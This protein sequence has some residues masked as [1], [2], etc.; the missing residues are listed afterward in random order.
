MKKILCAA[1]LTL[2]LA[3]TLCAPSHALDHDTLKV[4]LRFGTDAL[5]SVN[6]WNYNDEPAGSGY[7]LGYYDS[8]RSFVSLAETDEEKISITAS[9]NIY[10][11]SGLYYEALPSAGASVIGGYHLQLVEAFETAEEAALAAESYENA[12]LAF[13]SDG[14]YVRVGSY[15]DTASAVAAAEAWDGDTAVELVQPSS[16]GVTVTKYADTTILF[17]FDYGGLRSLGILPRSIDGERTRVWFKNRVYYGGFEYQRTTG[18]NISVINVVNIDDYVKCVITGEM[19]AD[20]PLEALK[21]QSVCARTYAAQQQRHKTSGFDVC[22]TDDCQVYYGSSACTENS[23]RAVD[24]TAGMYLYYNGEL[25]A[26]A[27][28]YSYNGG[29]SEDCKNV[30]YSDV[31]YLKGKADPYE[32]DIAAVMSGYYWSVSF[33]ADELTTILKTKLAAD[34]QIGRVTNVYVSE[35]TEMG[36][37]LAVTFEGTQGRYTARKEACRTIFNGVIGG[38]SVRSMRFTIGEGDA[39]TMYVNPEQNTLRS[40]SGTYVIGGSGE[41]FYYTGSS[42]TTYVLTADGLSPLR[43]QESAA[44]S[45]LFTLYGSGHGHNIGMSQWGAY[46]MAERGYD[47]IDILTF[48][49]TGVTVE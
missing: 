23:D 19:S 17:E 45:G 38:K 47:Y 24:E 7:A 27:V 13:L 33:T 4:G 16:T 1:A 40:I 34:K 26:N 30:W 31:P 49:Y 18:G 20:W 6:L 12:Y 35:F 2:L 36:N 37:V 44:K 11:A 32:A 39:Q 14:I 48:Y 22:T 25:V 9:G 8:D 29:A 46:A 15:T 41:T 5:F 43:E 10:V 28:Y 42:S 21:A 3:C